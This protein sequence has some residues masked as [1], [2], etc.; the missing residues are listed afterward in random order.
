MQ[1]GRVG[2]M[3]FP[4]TAGAE[5]LFPSTPL[6]AAPPAFREVLFQFAGEMLKVLF[7][8]SLSEN[9]SKPMTQQQVW[10]QG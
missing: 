9:N 4:G 8:H 6:G 10:L 2:E 5:Q 1:P 7:S 3:T